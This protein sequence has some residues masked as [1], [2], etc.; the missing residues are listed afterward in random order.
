MLFTEP[1]HAAASRPGLAL[2][3]LPAFL[4]CAMRK[5]A[6]MNKLLRWRRCHSSFID[7]CAPFPFPSALP[8][9]LLAMLSSKKLSAWGPTF[10]E[11]P[12]HNGG[13]RSVF[14][15]GQSMHMPERV[16][17]KTRMCQAQG[18][19]LAKH[20]APLQSEVTHTRLKHPKMSERPSICTDASRYFRHLGMICSTFSQPHSPC[21]G[22]W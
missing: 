9:H 20:A 16:D 19:E 22:N 3:G 1:L 10:Q 13:L 21:K 12:R 7:L 15:P 5:S 14:D 6:S 18:L 2:Q 17:S 4:P 11:L 8:S